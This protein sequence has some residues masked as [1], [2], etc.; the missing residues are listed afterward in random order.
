MVRFNRL[1]SFLVLVIFFITTPT[2]LPACSGVPYPILEIF[3]ETE[4]GDY[5]VPAIQNY[6]GA[7]NASCIPGVTNPVPT[8]RL[9]FVDED[10]SY[11][12]RALWN[13][14]GQFQIQ[15][16]DSQITNL[17]DQINLNA[18]WW[19][20]PALLPM[21]KMSLLA[22]SQSAIPAFMPLLGMEQEPQG[23]VYSNPGDKPNDPIKQM[24]ICIQPMSGYESDN[25]DWATI[26][27][28]KGMVSSAPSGYPVVP[29]TK[30]AD[31]FEEGQ[32]NQPLPTC[33]RNQMTCRSSTFD[34]GDIDTEVLAWL[35]CVGD[36]FNEVDD[37]TNPAT[38]TKVT[39]A[40]WD[41]MKDPKWTFSTMGVQWDW[42]ATEVVKTENPG[43]MSDLTGELTCAFP[44]PC[45]PFFIECRVTCLMLF[46]LRN[47]EYVWYEVPQT[48]D[49]TTDT[50]SPDSHLDTDGNVIPE[51]KECRYKAYGYFLRGSET[52]AS[53]STT[54]ICVRDKTPPAK[55]VYKTGP[56]SYVATPPVLHGRTGDLLVE[57]RDDFCSHTD[58][59]DGYINVSVVDNNPFAGFSYLTQAAGGPLAQL[60]DLRASETDETYYFALNN[61]GCKLFYLTELYDYCK[62]SDSSGDFTLA[63]NFYKPKLV[64]AQ[65]ATPSLGSGNFSLDSLNGA[66]I[67]E[68]MEGF[69]DTPVTKFSPD[70]MPADG[71]ETAIYDENGANIT[72]EFLP[73][74]N[75]SGD[76]QRLAAPSGAPKEPAYSVTTFKVPIAAFK[77][78]LPLH[79]SRN[80]NSQ[81]PGTLF[82]YPVVTDS[83]QNSAPYDKDNTDVKFDL[84]DENAVQPPDE[85]GAIEEL[86]KA[87]SPND[88]VQAEDGLAETATG[89]LE[90]FEIGNQIDDPEMA[91]ISTLNVSDAT[92]T[93][94]GT[95][96]NM[97]V[98]EVH[99]DEPPQVFIYVTDTK[100]VHPDTNKPLTYRFGIQKHGDAVRPGLMNEGWCINEKSGDINVASPSPASSFFSDLSS[101]M[102][103]T[104]RSYDL[105]KRCDRLSSPSSN[106]TATVRRNH[107]YEPTEEVVFGEKYFTDYNDYFSK[108]ESFDP[109]STYPETLP[110]CWVDEDSR[111]LFHVVAYDNCFTYYNDRP[112][113][114]AEEQP[115]GVLK[116]KETTDYERNG[117]KSLEWEIRDDGRDLG[118]AASASYQQEY[119]FRNPNV[120]DTFELNP[121]KECHVKVTALDYSDNARTVIVKFYVQNN[122]MRFRS[123]EEKRKG[124]KAW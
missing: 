24:C 41:L 75:V 30:L 34:G 71:I 77:E 117:I 72:A 36:T 123:L 107:T 68:E 104:L 112:G 93:G 99:D 27:G 53:Q 40:T 48:Y 31:V 60:T 58:Y 29:G 82:W 65:G 67:A 2:K 66:D 7:T 9:Y 32:A 62:A 4:D 76:I 73:R 81:R 116:R 113:S 37:G 19:E 46:N 98:I 124:W 45:E 105:T 43:T 89:T 63:K 50:W 10:T 54:L 103:G 3:L 17:T 12:F 118:T 25:T 59:P 90:S 115:A 100:Y 80:P 33:F 14:L 11:T 101:D 70:T 79:L 18:E 8:T 20:G 111:L 57:A 16:S 51:A 119:I 38:R 52:G 42:D 22:G 61:L 28:D 110:G 97:G 23:L 122:K 121:D 26:D 69:P 114:F 47:A 106:L 49:A 56:D 96:G 86:I 55:V 35:P 44:V 94:G 88:F 21:D 92:L 102:L 64:W 108:K 5:P 13:T 84:E 109:S 1:S 78:P 87:S 91:K 83:A 95:F 15:V 39:S 85:S 120:S 6:T 74:I